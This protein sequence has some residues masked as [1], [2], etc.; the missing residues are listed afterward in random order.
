MDPKTAPLLAE[1]RS[2]LS[3]REKELHA[4]AAVMLKKTFVQPGPEPDKDNGS[5]FPEKSKAFQAWCK[6]QHPKKGASS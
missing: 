1:W 3:E 2:T 5:Y 4:L 6:A